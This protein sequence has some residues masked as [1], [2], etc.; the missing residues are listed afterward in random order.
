MEASVENL[1]AYQIALE[2]SDR[3][4]AKLMFGLYLPESKSDSGR[5]EDPAFV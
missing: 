2:Q 4:A 3:A 1:N 5:E